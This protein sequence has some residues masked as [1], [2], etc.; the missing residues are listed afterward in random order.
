VEALN[1]VLRKITIAYA[2]ALKDFVE[3]QSPFFD[4]SQ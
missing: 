4:T 2:L 1:K 3:N